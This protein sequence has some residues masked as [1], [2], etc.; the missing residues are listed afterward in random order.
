MTAPLAEN[1]P[2][3]LV[4][5]ANRGIGLGL[6]RELKKHG[7]N[8][9]GTSRSTNN[10]DVAELRQVAFAIVQLD[11]SSEDSISSLP[12]QLRKHNIQRIDLLCNNAG[13]AGLETL[14]GISGAEMTRIFTT[15]AVGPM[16]ITKALLPLLRA[17]AS[18]GQFQTKVVQVSSTMGSIA[19]AGPDGMMS[20]VAYAYRASKAALNMLTRTLSV[21]LQ[22]DKIAC[23]LLCPGYVKSD[24]N[25]GNGYYTIEDSTGKLA[26]II[27]DA[28]ME[29][30]GKFIYVEGEEIPW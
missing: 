7:Y 14:D 12:E 10:K 11:T 29:T 4:T 1:A 6:A 9:I 13:V 18:H 20:G 8:I 5:G 15:N 23:L 3:A 22:K 25:H 21:E 26:K 30:T 24:M 16:L 27:K 28:T 2:I 19:K 17:S